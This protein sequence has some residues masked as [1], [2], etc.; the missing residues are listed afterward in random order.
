MQWAKQ[1]R[2]GSS[3]SKLVLIVLSDY[4]TPGPEEGPLPDGAAGRHFAYAGQERIARECEMSTESVRRHQ[5]ELIK[6]GHIRKVRRFDRA[7]HRL[8]DYI[9][10]A[11]DDHR[12]RPF[13][14]PDDPLLPVPGEP[15]A[16]PVPTD[17][18]RQDPTTGQSDRLALEGGSEGSLPHTS[19]RWSPYI[20]TTTKEP[21]AD[22]PATSLG[23]DGS[24]QTAASAPTLAQVAWVVLLRLARPY[25]LGESSAAQLRGPVMARLRQGWTP[26][27]LVAE[28]TRALP[29]EARYGLLRHR[30]ADLP[31][32]PGAAEPGRPESERHRWLRWC[33]DALCDPQTRCNYETRQ[34]CPTCSPQIAGLRPPRPAA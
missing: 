4:A 22:F 20:G 13:P 8:S 34:P 25:S 27:A 23:T 32:V 1:Q 16:D 11:V 5:L 9:V 33:G 19:D 28:L 17:D 15:P 6:Q 29:A 7:G 21:L 31:P 2:T 24:A 26:D 3:A 12:P 18:H 30:L 14:T 10:L